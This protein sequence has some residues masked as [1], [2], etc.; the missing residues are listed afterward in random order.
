[1]RPGRTTVALLCGLTLIVLSVG[2]QPHDKPVTAAQGRAQSSDEPANRHDDDRCEV[3][4][5]PLFHAIPGWTSR[6]EIIEFAKGSK[7]YCHDKDALDGWIHPGEYCPNG[8][9]ERLVEYADGQP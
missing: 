6:Q 7:A 5:A 8:C 2:C 1:M 3:C 4:G 9:T